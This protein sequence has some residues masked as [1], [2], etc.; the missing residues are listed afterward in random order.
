METLH[1]DCC[2][3]KSASSVS[4]R[5]RYV[6]VRKKL[7]YS[8]FNI[9]RYSEAGGELRIFTQDFSS[10]VLLTH[11]MTYPCSRVDAVIS[12]QYPETVLWMVQN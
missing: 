6:I 1:S 8:I 5:D 3:N 10:V 4:D 9:V 2:G 11:G 12:P 7:L